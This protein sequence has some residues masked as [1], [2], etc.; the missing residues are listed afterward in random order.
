MGKSVVPAAIDIKPAAVSIRESA[1]QQR[2]RSRF[3]VG[4]SGALLLIVLVGFART[5]YLRALFEVPEIPASVW[6][7]GIVL[8]AWFV[9]VFLQTM[10]VAVRR[11]D[12]H[13]QLGWIVGGLGVAVLAVS[14]AVTLNFVPRQR[15]LGVDIEARLHGLSVVVWSDFAALLAFAMFLSAAVA[16]RRRPEMHKRLMLL[17]S[18][19]IV[20][21]AMS[22][23]WRWPVFDGLDPSLLG[24]SGLLLFIL[25]LGLYDLIVCRRVHAVTLCC[26]SFFMG[27]KIAGIYVIAGSEVGLSFVRGL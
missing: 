16:L 4:M 10:L 19:S 17:S 25:A 6:L 7:H 21:P 9:G 2:P 8:T 14:M 5:L 11:T 22:R 1:P 24:L 3:Y 27:C 23:I 20:Q 15:A 12:M 26:G 18:I 13:R